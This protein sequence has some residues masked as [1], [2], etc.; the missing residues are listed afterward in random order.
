VLLPLARIPGSVRR[1]VG[2][3]TGSVPIPSVASTARQIRCAAPHVLGVLTLDAALL[4]SHNELIMATTLTL[5]DG[6]LVATST[7]GLRDGRHLVN[8]NGAG[9][10]VY[11]EVKNGKVAEY[12]AEHD[13]QP[14]QMVMIRMRDMTASGMPDPTLRWGKC[15]VCAEGFCWEV[16]CESWAG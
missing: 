10:K 3:L 14:V 4:P 16:S 1:R 12:H 5:L 11:V 13:G 2:D 7:D 6:P 15:M 8:D 9:T